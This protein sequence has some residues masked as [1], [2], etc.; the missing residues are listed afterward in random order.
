MNGEELTRP[1]GVGT[2]ILGEEEPILP[3]PSEEFVETAHV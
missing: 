1:T 3:E 2:A